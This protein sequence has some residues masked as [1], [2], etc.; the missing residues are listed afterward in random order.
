MGDREG[1]PTPAEIQAQE[2]YLLVEA[3]HEAG[4]RY[5]NVVDQIQEAVFECGADGVLTFVNP[6]W[7]NLLGFGVRHSTGRSLYD[8]IDASDATLVRESLASMKS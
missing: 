4:R 5:R 6:A 1:R 2:N 8:F 3:L 7:K